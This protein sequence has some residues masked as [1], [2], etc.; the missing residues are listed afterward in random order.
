M[1]SKWGT[2]EKRATSVRKCAKGASTQGGP[3]K[4]KEGLL[5]EIEN[6]FHCMFQVLNSMNRLSDLKKGTSQ[7]KKE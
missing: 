7:I 6:D 3:K 4:N 5:S 1:F 2:P